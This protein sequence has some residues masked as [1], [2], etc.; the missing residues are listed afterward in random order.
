MITDHEKNTKILFYEI[1]NH[2]SSLL[3][4][5]LAEYHIQKESLKKKHEIVIDYMNT[6]DLD[7]DLDEIYQKINKGHKN[8][9]YNI[10]ITDKDLVI[11]NATYKKDIGFDIS[12]A[13]NAFDRHKA[14]N[15][16]GC[17]TP[18]R[19]KI[20]KNFLSYTDSYLSKN[21]DDKSAIL[22]LSYA[23]EDTT[24]EI[25]GLLNII[26]KY[27]SIKDNKA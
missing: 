5:L 11:R 19:E 17:S 27:P 18:I 4:K 16:I 15:V 20:S 26:Q 10:Y 23:Y 6:H 2:T 3:S 1:K 25:T 12:F 14:E 13:K 7:V 9:P 22:Q 24:Q 8:K 21:G